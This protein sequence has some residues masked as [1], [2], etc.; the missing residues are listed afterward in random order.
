MGWHVQ[1]KFLL[2]SWCHLLWTE[3]VRP[4]AATSKLQLSL[5]LFSCFPI[6]TQKKMQLSQLVFRCC[7]YDLA[8][9][10]PCFFKKGGMGGGQQ[11]VRE[12]LHCWDWVT[13]LFSVKVEHYR[14]KAINSGARDKFMIWRKGESISGKTEH[15]FFVF[16]TEERKNRNNDQVLG[17]SKLF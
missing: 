6:L 7:R 9:C 1:F 3:Q 14:Q 5:L 2:S 10:G 12:Q 8:S 15:H 13:T 11:A 4:S 17:I 16:K